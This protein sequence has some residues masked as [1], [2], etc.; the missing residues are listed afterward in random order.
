MAEERFSFIIRLRRCHNRNIHPVNRGDAVVLDLRKYQLL[1][2]AQ[3]IISASV[4]CLG[5]NPS[6]IS[7]SRESQRKKTIEK[8]VHPVASKRDLRTDRHSLPKLKAGDR[9]FGFA[10]RPLPTAVAAGGAAI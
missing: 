10:R 4:E 7:N 5:G 2:Q 6:K 1:L 9:L 8:F 3:G